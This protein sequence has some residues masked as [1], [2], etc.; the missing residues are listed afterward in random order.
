MKITALVLGLA[1]TVFAACS[2]TKEA[3]NE[4]MEP[5]TVSQTETDRAPASVEDENVNLGASSSGM[6]H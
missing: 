6:S 3:K 4:P 2:S 1:L 5:M